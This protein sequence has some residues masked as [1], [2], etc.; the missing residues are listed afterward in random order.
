MK[1]KVFSG[2]F[3][4]AYQ[5]KSGSRPLRSGFS[6]LAHLRR[7]TYM[8]KEVQ[9]MYIEGSGGELMPLTKK[10]PEDSASIIK[11]LNSH[12]I[13]SSLTEEDKE[14]ITEYMQLYTFQ[15]GSYIF[16]QGMPSKSFYVIK[17]GT[18]EV[19]VNGKKVNKLNE[20]DGFGELAL[21]SSSERSATMRCLRPTNVWV[22]ERDLFKKLIEDISTQTF[23]QNRMFLDKI[24]LLASLYSEQKDSLAANMLSFKFKSGQTIVKE[25]ERGDTMF[26]IKEGTV[27]VFKSGKEVNQLK[28]GSVF[29]EQALI[30]QTVRNAT[31]VANG[32]P[33][34]CVCLSQETIHQVLKYGLKE[35]I[36]RNYI[37]E[38]FNKSS[39][40][41]ALKNFQRE[42]ILKEL[43]IVEY[44]S[45]DVIIHKGE[46]CSN[47]LYVIISGR[48]QNSRNIHLFADKGLCIGD[49][50]LGSR[51]S[52]RYE[53][54]FIAGCDMEIGEI[55]K[56]QLE[57][58]LGGK[59]E[60]IIKE[61]SAIN[62][63]RKVWLFDTVDDYLLKNVISKVRVL[64][65]Q[66]SEIILKEGRENQEL[67]ILKKGK[68]DIF[69]CGKLI[70]TVTKHGF[71][72]ENSV[73][74]NQIN[75]GTF[76]ASGCV[77]LWVISSLDFS[78]L[79]NENMLTQLKK[80]EAHLYS[81]IL[82][83]DLY[84]V[85]LLGKGLFSKVF[86]M[87]T[88]DRQYFALKTYTYKDIKKLYINQQILV[89]LI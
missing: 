23:E 54:D 50:F 49:E 4:S 13:F 61:N 27:L 64:T 26:I 34:Y 24:Q 30:T 42:A 75:V 85:Q 5:M 28:S 29:G 74:D 39:T 84:P 55:T 8:T 22:I 12:F 7:S 78:K 14:L 36:Q 81:K 33:V 77:Q 9:S 79:V 47:K 25:G 43:K 63:L 1:T 46:N 88:V 44:S 31:C 68:V 76:V 80:R 32:G 17:S 83:K 69:V 40:L 18:V 11:A 87:A 89:R 82:L 2:S 57:M 56:Y 70:R 19:M 71:F 51:D 10:S 62:I 21:I 48:M 66:D 67:F 20:G 15:E 58:I 72:G 86:L 16:K 65:Y 52:A 38:A 59:Y 3:D 41:G 60:D 37:M 45:G 73:L 53:D 35:I 6:Q